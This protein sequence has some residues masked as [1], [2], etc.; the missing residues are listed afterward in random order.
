MRYLRLTEKEFSLICEAVRWAEYV[1]REVN[2]AEGSDLEM[3]DG[4]I[5]DEIKREW[6]LRCTK[7]LNARRILKTKAERRTR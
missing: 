3:G 1:N 4:K 5:E 6:H 2:W 7:F